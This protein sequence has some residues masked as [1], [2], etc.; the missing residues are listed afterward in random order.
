M[1][2]SVVV[3]CTKRYGAFY[4]KGYGLTECVSGTHMSP[5]YGGKPES[6]GVLLPN[7]ECKVTPITES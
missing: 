6:C 3:N 1:V 7:M 5:P 4:F 2:F